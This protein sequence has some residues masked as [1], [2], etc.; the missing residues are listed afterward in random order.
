MTIL[1][2]RRSIARS[3]D[4]PCPCPAM[5]MPGHNFLPAGNAR[6]TAHDCEPRLTRSCEIRVNTLAVEI[7]HRRR[8]HPLRKGSGSHDR[9]ARPR[10]PTRRCHGAGAERYCSRCG[11]RVRPGARREAR[12]HLTSLAM[13]AGPHQQLPGITDALVPGPRPSGAASCRRSQKL[14]CTDTTAVPWGRG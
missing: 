14:S 13:A 4:I 11:H 10:L 1:L 6:H 5:A 2:R 9:D 8:R 3:N 7:A 12:P